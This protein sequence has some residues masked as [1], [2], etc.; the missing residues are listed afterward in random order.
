MAGGAFWWRGAE[1]ELPAIAPAAT[2]AMA[3]AAAMRRVAIGF[4]GRW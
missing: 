3:R 4:M 2:A 1:L